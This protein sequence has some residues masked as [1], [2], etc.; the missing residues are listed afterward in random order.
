[1]PL[2]TEILRMSFQSILLLF[3][4]LF[5]FAS[6]SAQT[7]SSQYD[8]AVSAGLEFNYLGTNETLGLHLEK[9]NHNLGIGLL[10][11]HTGAKLN[12]GLGL[13][14]KYRI[15]HTKSADQKLGL[16]YR[17]YKPLE[18]LH[19]QL[20]MFESQS[21]VALNK[22]INV[23]MAL[24]YGLALEKVKS[25]NINTSRNDLSGMFKIGCGYHF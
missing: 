10:H 4:S 15:I 5:L 1:M 17:S 25:V 14:Y 21:S 11:G 2:Y 18:E 16:A 22:R 13:D 20:F 6:A 3:S 9:L 8:L 23:Y 24:G 7:D 12:F 19:S